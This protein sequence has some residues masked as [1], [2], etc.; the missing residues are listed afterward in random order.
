MIARTKYGLTLNTRLSELRKENH[1]TQ[2]E[3]GELVGLPATTIAGYEAR[4][5][6]DNHRYPQIHTVR[7]LAKALNTTTDYLL[8][9]TDEVDPPQETFDVAYLFEKNKVTVDG[10][11]LDS[12]ICSYISKTIKKAVEFQKQNDLIKQA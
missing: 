5:S 2:K 1:Y 7:K 11:Q 3:L 12:E 6:A 4:E 10:V 8:G 9:L